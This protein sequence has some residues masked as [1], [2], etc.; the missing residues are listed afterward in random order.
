MEHLMGQSCA[1]SHC[2]CILCCRLSCVAVST[3]LIAQQS[4]L[5]PLVPSR[6][7]TAQSI[8][9]ALPPFCR[10]G[11]I[12]TRASTSAHAVLDDISDAHSC[13][14]LLEQYT[15]TGDL[16]PPALIACGHTV[17]AKAIQM[18]LH[19][20][21]QGVPGGG[22][23]API[24]CPLCNTPQAKVRHLTLSLSLSLCSDMFPRSTEI[25]V[26]DRT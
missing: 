8:T 23:T 12:M 14:V 4:L 25:C 9:A 16:Q 2:D 11:G 7:A 26:R 13:P 10:S 19:A 3:F 24:Q 17:S 21:P 20:A 1:L 22:S 15:T 5:H 18:L 6:S